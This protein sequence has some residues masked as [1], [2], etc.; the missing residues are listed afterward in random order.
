SWSRLSMMGSF[1]SETCRVLMREHLGCSERS[2]QWVIA[3]LGQAR[4]APIPARRHP[5]AGC[6]DSRGLGAQNTWTKRDPAYRGQGKQC[7]ALPVGET[8]LG[9]CEKRG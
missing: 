9:P 2:D 8:S 4:C 7:P 1:R 3:S 6:G 5:D